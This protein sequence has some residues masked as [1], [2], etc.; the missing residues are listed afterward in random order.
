MLE[1]PS[2]RKVM[3]RE[4]LFG[5]CQACSQ[6]VREISRLFTD[7]LTSDGEYLRRYGPSES[8]TA[9]TK[10]MPGEVQRDDDQHKHTD[11]GVE[12]LHS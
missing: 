5:D 2:L 8:V 1:T 3:H 7:R 4:F 12:D 10:T 9:A 6:I 11:H